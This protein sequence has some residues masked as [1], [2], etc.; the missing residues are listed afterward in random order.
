MDIQI[1]IYA[2]DIGEQEQ[3]N[4]MEYLKSTYMGMCKRNLPT[5]ATF[6]GAP[7]VSL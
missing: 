5:M 4:V 6:R 7:L 2:P 3:A 1:P